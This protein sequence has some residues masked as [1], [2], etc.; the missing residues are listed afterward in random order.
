[1]SGSGPTVAALA[2]TLSH[3]ERLALARARIDRDERS[4]RS[5]ASGLGRAHNRDRTSGVV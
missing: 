5:G 2:S 1:M 3:A 4:A